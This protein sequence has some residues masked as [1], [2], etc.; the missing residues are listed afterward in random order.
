MCKSA[1]VEIHIST[2]TEILTS[3]K[4]GEILLSNLAQKTSATNTLLLKREKTELKL[5]THMCD[6][7]LN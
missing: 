1:E 5:P 4:G 7:I 2:S 3:H 6:Y